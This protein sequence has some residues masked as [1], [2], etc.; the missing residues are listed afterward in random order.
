MTSQLEK[1]AQGL[2]SAFHPRPTRC[3]RGASGRRH[4]DSRVAQACILRPSQPARGRLARHRLDRAPGAG[5]RLLR[6]C[7]SRRASARQLR[8]LHEAALMSQGLRPHPGLTSR[9]FGGSATCSFRIYREQCANRRGAGTHREF[10]RA[11]ARL[12]THAPLAT[13]LSFR[14]APLAP[15][16]VGVARNA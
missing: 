14:R 4:R 13:G 2:D 1:L 11:R 5:R 3:A 15:R 6:I 8:V 12:T 10:H 7:R 9:A 16:G